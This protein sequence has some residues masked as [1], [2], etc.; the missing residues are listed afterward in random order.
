[1]E[2][3]TFLQWEKTVLVFSPLELAFGMEKAWVGIIHHDYSSTAL[4]SFMKKCVLPLEHLD[5][6]GILVL[7][8]TNVGS[9]PKSAVPRHFSLSY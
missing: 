3:M 7:M 9:T 8:S 2:R 6:L 5:L 1:M 4:C